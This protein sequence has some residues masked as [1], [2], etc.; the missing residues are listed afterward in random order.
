MDRQDGFRRGGYR[1]A[2]VLLLT[3]TFVGLVGKLWAAAL[4]VLVA[5]ALV[6]VVEEINAAFLRRAEEAPLRST[7]AAHLA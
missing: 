7:S 3:A 2:G 4:L 1:V 5:V 6:A